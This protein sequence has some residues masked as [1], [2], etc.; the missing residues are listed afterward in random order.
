MENEYTLPWDQ[1]LY[2]MNGTD[3]NGFPLSAS[4]ITIHEVVEKK[5]LK[6]HQEFAIIDTPV[7]VS[8]S[9]G[10][11]VAAFNFPQKEKHN[12]ENIKKMCINWLEHI[13]ETS[14][15]N[16]LLS[17]IITPVLM[18]GTFTLLLTDLV[19]AEGYTL[20]D[21]YRLILCFDNNKT[22]PYILDGINISEM[23]FEID[24]RIEQE[25]NEIRS[26]IYE[27]EE[28]IKHHEDSNLYEENIKNKI[29]NITFDKKDE[30]D[31]LEEHTGI[32]VSKEEDSL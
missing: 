4:L 19:F 14:D 21:E 25:L 7:S 10:C 31:L 2:L 29:T 28:I 22:Q 30:D 11:V 32:R 18:E 9:G 24:S 17:L 1:I 27:A 5:Q 8:M 26:S 3:V 16:K 6:I 12:Y 23:V 15:D 20:N 13:N